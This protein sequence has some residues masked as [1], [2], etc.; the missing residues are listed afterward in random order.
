MAIV[1]IPHQPIDFTYSENGA[2]ENL[3][4]MCLQYET[5]DNPMLQVKGT[6]GSVPMITIQSTGYSEFEEVSITPIAQ[7]NGYYTFQL[8]FEELGITSGCFEVCVY[9]ATGSTLVTNGTFATDLT[10]WLAID[11]LVLDITSQINP[12]DHETCDGEVVLAANGGTASYVYSMDGVNYQLS[13]TFTGL[14]YDVQ[15]TFYAKDSYGVV[16]SIVFTFQDCSLF[17]GSEAFDIK[18]IIAFEIK[19]CEAFDFV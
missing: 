17:A 9:E 8:N 19:N 1:L 4:S 2:C 15:Y 12:T 5:G 7:S 14:C 6:N 13:D 16:D 18:N 10:G 11:G 3:S